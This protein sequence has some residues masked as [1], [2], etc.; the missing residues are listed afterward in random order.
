MGNRA[1]SAKDAVEILKLIGRE[2]KQ[3]LFLVA[4]SVLFETN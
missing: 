2:F 4:L 3:L 1:T